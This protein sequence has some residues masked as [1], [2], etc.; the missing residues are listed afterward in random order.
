M[1]DRIKLLMAEYGVSA[2]KFA[3]K[4]GVQAS[5]ISHIVSGR[6]KPGYD[7]IVKVLDAYPDVSPDWFLA[8]KG[9]MLREDKH[10]SSKILND[11][12]GDMSKTTSKQKSPASASLQEDSLESV[13][14]QNNSN[15][16]TS[17]LQQSLYDNMKMLT[18]MDNQQSMTYSLPSD[19]NIDSVIILY[20][21]KTFKYYKNE[22]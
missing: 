2:N 22:N 4:I 12:M 1:N 16:I 8:G 11:A 20:S 13:K 21:D 10:S 19:K 17:D 18:G 5:S 15:Y 7:F 6:N 9:P 3:E 14:T